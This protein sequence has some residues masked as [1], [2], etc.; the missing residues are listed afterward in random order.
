MAVLSRNA[1][2]PCSTATLPVNVLPDRFSAETLCNATAPPIVA[3]PEACNSRA[4]L[5]WHHTELDGMANLQEDA[6]SCS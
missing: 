5:T 3:V 2:P 6:P 1:A 4:P